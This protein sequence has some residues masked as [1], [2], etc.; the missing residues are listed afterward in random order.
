MQ[1]STTVHIHRDPSC[2]TILTLDIAPYD[3][4][5]MEYVDNLW[6]QITI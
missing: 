4:E 6:L 1:I 2:Y 5:D 3:I